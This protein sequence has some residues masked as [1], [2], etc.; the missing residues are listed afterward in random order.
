MPPDRFDRI[1]RL[2]FEMNET[3]VAA[4]CQLCSTLDKE[5]NVAAAEKLVLEA[6]E[7]GAQLVALPELFNALGPLPQVIALAEPI[8]GPTSERCSQ[9][10]ARLNITLCAGSICEKADSPGHGFNTSLL[11]GPDGTLLAKYR[12]MHLFDA[13]IPGHVTVKESEF[14]LPGETTVVTRHSGCEYGQAICYD[15]RFPEVFRQLAASGAEI[16]FLPSAFTLATGPDHWEILLRARA[17]ENQAFVVAPNQCGRHGPGLVSYGH[18]MIVDP[19]GRVLARASGDRQEIVYAQLQSAIL[20]D[21][22]RKLP[23]LKHRRL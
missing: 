13:D 12:K 20:E 6:A 9:W 18:S 7:K 5:A 17:I 16:I 21:M 8:P 10:A 1:E 22:R 2:Q 3:I 11:F 15:L 14:M 19:W 23:A 4:V